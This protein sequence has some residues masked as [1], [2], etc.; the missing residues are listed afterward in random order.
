MMVCDRIAL[1]A[2]EIAAQKLELKYAKSR[3]TLA[4][5][6]SF[7]I[8]LPLWPRKNY[9]AARFVVSEPEKWDQRLKDAGIETELK[10]GRV[11]LHLHDGDL[12]KNENV[13]R[14]LIHQTVKE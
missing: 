10:K 2:N 8:V 13:L 5:P 12:E 11:S 7:F 6:G 3:V 4:V 9:V 1:I 14:E